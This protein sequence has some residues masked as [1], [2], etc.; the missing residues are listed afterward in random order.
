MS[1]AIDVSNLVVQFPALRAVDGVTFH[2]PYGQVTSL[3]GPN[4]AGKTTLVE[5]LLGFRRPTQGTVRLHGLDPVRD[6]AEV[7]VRTGALLQR[8]GVWSSMRRFRPVAASS[9]RARSAVIGNL[10]TGSACGSSRKKMPRV[11]RK[12]CA[13]CGAIPAPSTGVRR[14]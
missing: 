4:G 6:H 14:K 13:I 8:G 12:P 5:T 7:V 3:L 11:A 9:S 1:Y 2:V 10:A